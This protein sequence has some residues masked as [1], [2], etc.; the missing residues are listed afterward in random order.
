M[1]E[2]TVLVLEDDPSLKGL[3]VWLLQDEGYE[4]VEAHDGLQ[5]IQTLDTP[6]PGIADPEVA[7]VDVTQPRLGGRKVLQHVAEHRHGTAVVAISTSDSDLDA[8]RAD[9]AAATIRKPFHLNEL[10][11]LVARFSKKTA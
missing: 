2:R 11:D 7:L 10:L 5:A 3:I 9:G 8:A 1:S 4:V 6:L